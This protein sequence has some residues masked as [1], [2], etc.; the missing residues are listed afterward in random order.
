MRDTGAQLRRQSSNGQQERYPV[1]GNTLHH[2]P[3]DDQIPVSRYSAHLHTP[4]KVDAISQE[5]QKPLEGHQIAASTGKSNLDEAAFTDDP[6][7]NGVY[8]TDMT[9]ASQDPPTNTDDRA[10]SASVEDKSTQ[11]AK[12][13]I[14]PRQTRTSSLRARLAAGNVVKTN[15]SKVT[16]FTDFTSPKE[17]TVEKNRESSLKSRM[18]ARAR[19]SIT[20]PATLITKA[21][22]ESITAKRA[23]AQ[24]VAGS[25]RTSQPR[26][27]SS[28]GSLRSEATSQT[29]PAPTRTAPA[30]PDT[31]DN[32]GDNTT[33]DADRVESSTSHRRTSSIPVP[34]K[35]LPPA[36]SGQESLAPEHQ[37]G[38]K[39]PG[40]DHILTSI[41]ES[42]RP[43]Y[44]FRRLSVQAPEYGPTLKISRSADRLI[45]GPSDDE[46]PLI[47]KES[48]ENDRNPVKRQLKNR[49]SNPAISSVDK[50]PDRLPR[51]LSS[52]G[53][54]KLGSRVGLIDS[55]T[56]EKKVK[57]ADLNHL[58]LKDTDGK[59]G[60]KPES[61]TL[62]P[63]PHGVEAVARRLGHPDIIPTSINGPKPN[64]QKANTTEVSQV[65]KVS[66]HTKENPESLT[67]T[68]VPHN[69]EPVA[70]R[71]GHPDFVPSASINGP[72]PNVQKMKVSGVSQVAK[73]SEPTK[74]SQESLTLT[75]V[76]HNI[77]PV[78]RR[79]GHPDFVP[80]AITDKLKQLAQKTEKVGKAEVMKSPDRTIEKQ[81]SLTL[82]PV[83]HNISPVARKL[84]HPVFE[85]AASPSRSKS[86]KGEAEIFYTAKATSNTRTTT[87][88]SS[89]TKPIFPKSHQQKADMS[90]ATKASQDDPQ[91]SA[92]RVAG[93]SD[94][95]KASTNVSNDPFFD[96]PE[97]LDE[98]YDRYG[99]RE[100]TPSE[101][102]WIAPLRVKS[103]KQTNKNQLQVQNQEEEVMPLEIIRSEPYTATE[104]KDDAHEKTGG[105]QQKVKDRDLYIPEADPFHDENII[106]H[107]FATTAVKSDGETSSSKSSTPVTIQRARGDSN[108]HTTDLDGHPLRS[109]SRNPPPGWN[110][111][112]K[113]PLS[114][115]R[116]ATFPPPTPPKDKVKSNSKATTSSTTRA[117]GTEALRKKRD[118]SP[119]SLYRLPSKQQTPNGNPN[120][121]ESSKLQGSMSKSVFS[122]LKG[123]FHKRSNENT[124]DA[125]STVKP[126]KS[127]TTHK[128]T[129]QAN[130][131]PYPLNSEANPLH[132]PTQASAARAKT[133]TPRPST[134][135]SKH[136]HHPSTSHTNSIDRR[137]ST[138]IPV[139]PSP[140]TSSAGGANNELVMQILDS[141]KRERFSPKKEQLLE[142]GKVLVDSI[143]QAHEAEKAME[144]AKQA[145]R[146]AE[147]ANE[148]CKKAVRDVG[149]CVEKWRRG[150]LGLGE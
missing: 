35:A 109:S 150:S 23:P 141:A 130:G 105:E 41:E 75:P 129:V 131:S 100:P 19:R 54:S 36:P 14:T 85:P 20:P 79:L 52:Q 114:P 18:Q 143:T 29:P 104:R 61:R 55:K 21:S 66:E 86:I 92:R 124:A 146:R 34:A 103:T 121:I 47:K 139:L 60:E 90:E 46:R 122:N 118:K 136:Q 145:A 45:L 133:S 88:Q 53:L 74:Q 51:P 49:K 144:E 27:P 12:P 33:T 95:S 76:P 101:E 10:R 73:A 64:A 149:V 8:N 71:L 147:V 126:K 50:K 80:P 39:I 81:E 24:F 107:D 77:E 82:I 110:D 58:S 70:R 120:S 115:L 28:R 91:M 137:P 17:T 83:P 102:S 125:Q 65:A 42:P 128:A 99:E 138:T 148:L 72:K 87:S 4:P 22:R 38:I 15:Q 43:K 96:A 26:R 67:L 6:F 117:V 30:V 134:S 98:I 16:G 106:V 140:K 89:P 78:A 127:K 59:G 113:S 111:E 57:S 63:V 25:R 44:Q 9:G 94:G 2:K 3:S 119:Q 1:L 32:D 135:G 84:G 40:H 11:G 5:E 31:A 56:R 97:Q 37:Q 132:R 69:I 116:A 108:G 142:L 48:K 13:T 112:S 123:L 7:R 68:P 62:T 93:A